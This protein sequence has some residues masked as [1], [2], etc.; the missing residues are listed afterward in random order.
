MKKSNTTCTS[1]TT[2][3]PL[4]EKDALTHPVGLSRRTHLSLVGDVFADHVTES[5]VSFEHFDRTEQFIQRRFHLHPQ[6]RKNTV[7]KQVT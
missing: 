6:A 2:K 4:F 7:I 1:K 3:L 5:S